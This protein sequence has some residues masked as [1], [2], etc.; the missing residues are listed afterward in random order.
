ME[1]KAIPNQLPQDINVTMT[2][3]NNLQDDFNLN[4][5]G[6]NPKMPGHNTDYNHLLDKRLRHGRQPHAKAGQ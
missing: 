5:S 3:I 6:F 2:N 4:K 1:N